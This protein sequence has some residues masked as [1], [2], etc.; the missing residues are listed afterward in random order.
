MLPEAAALALLDNSPSA[1]KLPRRIE[2]L[3]RFL[4]HHLST[5]LTVTV[6][7]ELCGFDVSVVNE[8]IG[9]GQEK[10]KG[11]RAMT[12]ELNYLAFRPPATPTFSKLLQ[13]SS[14][15]ERSDELRG[16]L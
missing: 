11:L 3:Y 5:E 4:L 8:F 15:E 13:V 9:G 16:Y 6:I 14:G 12:V 7:D 2:A 1:V 10:A